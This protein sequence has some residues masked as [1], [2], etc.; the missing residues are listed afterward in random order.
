MGIAPSATTL[1]GARAYRDDYQT[2]LHV[3]TARVIGAHPDIELAPYNTGSMHVPTAPQRGKDVFLPVSDYPHEE[4]VKK[5]GRG[6]DAFVNVTVPYGIPAIAEYTVGVE[7]W[8]GGAVAE[9]VYEAS[10]A[11]ANS[12]SACRPSDTLGGAFARRYR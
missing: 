2:V 10:S 7:R 11:S 8:H 5:R 3:D 4:W 9:V 6:G 1:L 12:S